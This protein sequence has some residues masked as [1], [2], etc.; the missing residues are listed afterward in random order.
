MLYIC[1]SVGVFSD[2]KSQR[3]FVRWIKGALESFTTYII[4]LL[5]YFTALRRAC[6]NS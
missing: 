4:V 6:K 1:A 5:L 2:E 3:V